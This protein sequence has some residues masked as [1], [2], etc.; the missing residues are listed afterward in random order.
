APGLSARGRA[1]CPAAASAAVAIR[2]M[3]L[4]L[5]GFGKMNHLVAEMAGERGHRVAKTL[6]Q[7]DA[8][9]AGWT[10]GLVAI[11]FSIPSAVL[12]HAEQCML[13]GI[14]L[15]IGTTG[16]YEHMDQVRALVDS[17]AVGAIYGAN[18]SVG[19]QAFYRAVQAAAAALPADY[20][21]FVWEAH[22]RHKLDAPSGTAREVAA[23]LLAAGHPAAVASTRAGSLP[24]VHTVGFDAPEDTLTIT[25][26]ARSMR[27]FAAGALWA[28]EWIRGRRGLHEFSSAW[29]QK[30]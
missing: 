18:F 25:H 27:G 13:A 29:E 7:G 26:T 12:P 16:W 10:A 22:H 3:D 1:G 2:A 19:V 15:V 21:A 17:A 30:I 9:P 6:D 4:L 8:W 11:D 23:R 14:P 28:A 20:E 5:L 24:G